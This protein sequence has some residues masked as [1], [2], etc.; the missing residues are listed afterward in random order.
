VL[1]AVA[2]FFVVLALTSIREPR[3]AGAS[4]EHETGEI[5]SSATRR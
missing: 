1:V 2:T 3:P 5:V 4:V